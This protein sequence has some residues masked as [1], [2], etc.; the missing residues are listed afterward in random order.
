MVLRHQGYDRG[1]RAALSTDLARAR[2]RCEGRDALAECWPQA[3]PGLQEHEVRHKDIAAT[4]LE[5]TACAVA[6]LDDEC[7]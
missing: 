2:W 6:S 4:P 3:Q 5:G 7:G 1:M